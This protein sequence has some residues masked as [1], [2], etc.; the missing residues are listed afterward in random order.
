MDKPL[1]HIDDA[2]RDIAEA[3]AMASTTGEL[4]FVAELHRRR[5]FLAMARSQ[6]DAAAAAFGD[7]LRAA[8]ERGHRFY[9]L[10][11]ASSLARLWAERGERGKAQGLLAPICRWFTDG[12]DMVDLLEAR[13]LLDT[14]G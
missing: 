12:A 14:L 11:A 10:R 3:L 4:Q 2:E 6:P 13:K 9:E 5:G 7:A 8:R 1:G